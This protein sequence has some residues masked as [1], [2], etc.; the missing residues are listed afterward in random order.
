ML[1]QPVIENSIKH[2]IA[3]Q[4][5]GNINVHFWIDEKEN[6]LLCSVMDNGIGRNKSNELKKQNEIAHQS[7]ATDLIAERIKLYNYK[8]KKDIKFY[9]HYQLDFIL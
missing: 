3:G 6:N 5:E 2:G 7:I 1:I 8:R 9:H 4:K